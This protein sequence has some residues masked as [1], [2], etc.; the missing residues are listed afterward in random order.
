MAL[1]HPAIPRVRKAQASS[2]TRCTWAGLLGSLHS[3]ETRQ[4]VCS[5]YRQAGF[6]PE[7]FPSFAAR[8]A[9]CHAMSR[10]ED[11]LEVMHGGRMTAERLSLRSYRRMLEDEVSA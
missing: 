6:T 3:D 5:A 1:S 9:A 7:C 2:G 11:A 8:V 10:G 4:L